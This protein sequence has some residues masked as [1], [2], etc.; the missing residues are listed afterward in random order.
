MKKIHLLFSNIVFQKFLV[1]NKQFLEVIR[2]GSMWTL[3]PFKDTDYCLRKVA[4]LLSPKALNPPETPVFRFL[5]EEQLFGAL[6]GYLKSS[7]CPE[8]N[9][10]E[11]IYLLFIPLQLSAQLLVGPYSV[12]HFFPGIYISA[13]LN[14]K[15]GNKTCPNY[16]TYYSNLPAREVQINFTKYSLRCPLDIKHFISD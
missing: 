1:T 11:R 9:Y 14:W 4:N 3:C 16:I 2:K 8:K 6:V 13:A 15:C 7:P 12:Y 10:E 5:Y